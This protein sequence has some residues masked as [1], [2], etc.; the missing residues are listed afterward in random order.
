MHTIELFSFCFLTAKAIFS[1]EKKFE[2]LVSEY[3]E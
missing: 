3:S 1:W 2:I